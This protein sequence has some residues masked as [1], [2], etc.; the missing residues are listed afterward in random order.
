MNDTYIEHEQGVPARRKTIRRQGHINRRKWCHDNRWDDDTPDEEILL[1]R[2]GKGL[3]KRLQGERRRYY[4][5]IDTP[6]GGDGK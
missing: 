5:E 1:D 2:R 3:G 4:P 6:E